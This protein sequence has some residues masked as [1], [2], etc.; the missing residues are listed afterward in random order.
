MF[1]LFSGSDF[2]RLTL[3]PVH[4]HSLLSVLSV[5]SS[6]LN[7]SLTIVPSHPNDILARYMTFEA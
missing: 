5:V 3:M 4:H 1:S 2:F 7:I 6:V